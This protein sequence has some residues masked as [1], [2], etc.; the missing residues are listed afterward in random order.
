LA[1]VPACAKLRKHTARFAQL[2][3]RNFN[4]GADLQIH[5]LMIIAE[6]PPVH[7]RRISLL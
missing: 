3:V 6:R 4:V 1:K 7:A 2:L 5:L